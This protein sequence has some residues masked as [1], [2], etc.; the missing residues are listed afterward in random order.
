[1]TNFV[2]LLT[3]D[4]VDSGHKTLNNAK[5]VMDNLLKDK[6]GLNEK[7]WDYKPLFFFSFFLPHQGKVIETTFANGARQLV[8]QLALETML[9]S[10]L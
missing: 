7:K 6:N 8:V 1:M 3:G 4:R 9:R 10:G 2:S 5:S